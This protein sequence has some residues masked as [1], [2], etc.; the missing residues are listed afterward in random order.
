MH[1]ELDLDPQRR[2]GQT[3][4]QSLER[5]DSSRPGHADSPAVWGR[6]YEQDRSRPGRPV[7]EELRDRQE[8]GVRQTRPDRTRAGRDDERALSAREIALLADIGRF[9]VIRASDL[10]QSYF[11]GNERSLR[12]SLTRLLSAGLIEDHVLTRRRGQSG[13]AAASVRVIAL[14]RAGKRIA[15]AQSPYSREQRLYAGLVKPREA[16]HD[17]NLYRLFQAHAT[18]L[19]RAGNRVRRVVLDFELKR[20]YLRELRRRERRDPST[21]DD[22]LKREAAAQLGL[23][24]I[25]GKIQFPDLRLESEDSLGQ[26]SKVDLELATADYRQ[27]SLTAKARAGFTLYAAP[28]DHGRLGSIPLDDHDLVAGILSF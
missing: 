3:A 5:G 22:Q 21:P 14:T 1:R 9:R 6:S 18:K 26:R 11:S 16:L 24:I 10:R 19:E 13:P 20:E 17:S 8:H 27:G 23:H 15:Q 12:E 4:G 7:R 2:A 25:E 28:G